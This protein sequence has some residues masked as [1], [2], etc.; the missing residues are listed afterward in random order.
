MLMLDYI[1]Y[2]MINK[3]IRLSAV[4]GV[5]FLLAKFITAE[6]ANAT[7]QSLLAVD[8]LTWISLL[9]L[10]LVI[11]I[12]LAYMFL[13][14]M[15][16]I[17]VDLP[18]GVSFNYTSMNTFFNT[19]LPLKGG[20]WIRGI[21]LKK[22]YQVPWNKYLFVVFTGQLAQLTLVI[23]ILVTAVYLTDSLFSALG[24]RV[25]NIDLTITAVLLI[26]GLMLMLLIPK[27]QVGAR[28]LAKLKRGLSLWANK[29]KLIALFI[30]SAITLNILTGLRLWLSF[31]S[32]GFSVGVWDI[33]T[34]YCILTVGLSWAFTPGNLGVRETAIVLV[35]S[36]FGIDISTALA[37]S[38]VDRAASLV[39]II[40]VGGITAHIS[41]RT[42]SNAIDE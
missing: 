29:P 11:F 24:N 25:A 23:G 26:I 33:V 35:S 32:V 20:L 15:K 8:A 17:G 6:R 7:F 31:L 40:L 42:S 28:Y 34:I 30:S 19:V 4:I 22:N 2:S 12:V 16:V 9:S 21:Y 38:I 39:V 1:F 3:I 14:S 41:S 5:V 18:F 10:S 13:I 27:T 36:L 37:A